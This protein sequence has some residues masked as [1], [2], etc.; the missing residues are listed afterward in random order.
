M[1]AT[2]VFGI[3]WVVPLGIL[4]ALWAKAPI[5]VMEK[6]GRLVTI[7][8]VGREFAKSMKAKPVSTLPPVADAARFEAAEYRPAGGCPPEVAGR[9]LAATLVTAAV[10]GLALGF[11]G[12][13]LINRIIG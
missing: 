12:L 11:L 9:L 8:G 7:A 6:Q 13:E 4:V 1:T 5:R 10:L 2:I 3:F